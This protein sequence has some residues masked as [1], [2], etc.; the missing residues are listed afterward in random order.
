MRVQLKRVCFVALL[1]FV[2]GGFI[3]P[4]FAINDLR[5]SS[6]HNMTAEEIQKIV[7]ET[8]GTQI[9]RFDFMLEN[10]P[11]VLAVYGVIPDKAKGIEA[12]EYW[13]QMGN[14]SRALADDEVMQSYHYANGGVVIGQG[15][16]CVC[17]TSIMVLDERID[18]LTEKDML[19]IKAR[20][21][22]YASLE[23]LNDAPLVFFK[24]KMIDSYLTEEQLLYLY[25]SGYEGLRIY[26]GIENLTDLR[27][28]F[29]TVSMSSNNYA[30]DNEGLSGDPSLMTRIRS[31]FG[32]SAETV[33]LSSASNY[34]GLA[35]ERVRPMVGG[36]MIAT[37]TSGGTIGYAAK[38]VND[39]DSRG[40]VTV[41][42][43]FHFENATS[44][45]P[46]QA[47]GNSNAIGTFSKM[48]KEGDSVF[49]P[50]NASD[51]KAA[52]YTGERDDQLLDVIGYEGAI[53][54]GMP[55]CKSGV[56]S[57]NT[58]G[59]YYGVRYNQTFTVKNGTINYTVNHVGVIKELSTESYSVPGDSGGPIYV[60]TRAIVNGTEQ[61]VAV[62]L[63]I[64]EGG[65]GDGTV[66]YVPCTE[67]RDRLGVV[68]LT[69]NDR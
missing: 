51:V 46:R 11:D 31:I 12:Y 21:D 58:E 50:L 7:D 67:I 39:S 30:F 43:V 16:Q 49:I 36:L 61:D 24:G 3:T 27:S 66:Y 45:Q 22:Y 65:D 69:L 64:L 68:P 6:Y 5:Y 52:I 47:Y 14:I 48:S 9:D 35:T 33:K 42:H 26:D 4:T 63:G 54:S 34:D 56:V 15:T 1:I 10:N 60:K 40:I 29:E 57:G 32:G 13:L 53:S 37:S 17:Y 19:A 28:D 8:T 23:G 2:I 62:L 59:T 55:L 18:E 25:D 44:Y 20:V 41:A 38:E